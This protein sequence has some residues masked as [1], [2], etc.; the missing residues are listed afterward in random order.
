M[1]YLWPFGKKPNNQQ[2]NK[3]ETGAQQQTHKFRPFQPIPVFFPPPSRSQVPPMGPL[4][5]PPPPVAATAA[6]GPQPPQAPPLVGQQGPLAAPQQP[7]G[8]QNVVVH[9]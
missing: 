2:T 6:V 5:P 8:L 1:G 7:V 9:R 3:E 4:V